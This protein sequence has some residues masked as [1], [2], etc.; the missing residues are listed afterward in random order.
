[1]CSFQISNKFLINYDLDKFK[2]QRIKA[3]SC[4]LQNRKVLMLKS[5]SNAGGLQ[6]ISSSLGEYNC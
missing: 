5:G 4:K 2:L 1:M 3:A 6:K